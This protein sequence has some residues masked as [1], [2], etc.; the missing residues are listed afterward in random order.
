V[1]LFAE[2]KR[3]NV[4]RV[5]IA[6]GVV[7]WLLLQVIAT[8]VP[9]LEL[10]DWVAKLTL[11]VLALGF[12]PT[13]IF[14]WAYELTPE[15]IKPEAEVDRTQSIRPQTG[16][17]LDRIII[18]FLVLA[19]GYFAYDKFA[20]PVGGLSRP[21]MASAAPVHP[22]QLPLPTESPGTANPEQK[23]IAVLPFVNMSSDPEQ[24]YFSDGVT[25][26][27]LNRLATIRGLQVAA[28]TSAFSFKGHNQDV[29]EIAQQLGVS[30][31]LEGSVRKADG[32]VRITAQ[33][34]RASDGFHLWSESYDRKLENIFAIQDEIASQIAAALEISLGMP[35][36]SSGQAAGQPAK[37]VNP[38]V[39]DLYL[40]A[41]VLHRQRGEGVSEAIELFQQALAIDPEFAP[42]WAGLS[43][44]YI[45]VPNYVPVDNWQ[46]LGDV[47]E[48]S[49]AAAEKALE[50]DPDLPTAT[51]AMGNNLFFRFEWARA[52]DY[53]ERALQLDPDSADIMEDYASLLLG[54]WQLDA[55]SKVIERMLA[56][57]PQVPIFLQTL[58]TQHDLEGEFELRD[59]ATQK[60]LE[61]NPDLGFLQ[62]WKLKSLLQNHQYDEARAYAGSMN[63]A[64]IDQQ[65]GQALVDWMQHPEQEPGPGVLRALG[66]ITFPAM[67]AGRYDVW[68]N[69]VEANGAQWPEWYTDGL[70]DL[71]A[72]TASPETMHCFRADPRTKALLMKLNLP[73][74]WRKVGWPDMCEPIGAD[75]FECH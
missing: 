29:R 7:S 31:I 56:L 60:A 16:R 28:R 55:A 64:H 68:I 22:A 37:Q 67:L 34:I 59:Q 15:G 74:Y 71:L 54:S 17:K 4:F 23:S 48:K 53:Y 21:S 41:R 40:R 2:L 27:I 5:G 39:Y 73:E 63:P 24:E 36:Q 25:E 18:A 57:D 52:Q 46:R 50:L 49:M 8:V 11:L 47:L 10:P 42:A 3:R 32:Q 58:T 61:I 66:F 38:E 43:H 62:A 70:N 20:T 12:I 65:A 1:S 30:N 26:E 19:L 9:I 33:L 14:A 51:H 13:L 45:V 69:A 44:S 75:D 6:Y 72:P 35:G